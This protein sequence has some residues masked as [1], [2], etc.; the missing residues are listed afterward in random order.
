[1]PLG[2]SFKFGDSATRQS[3]KAALIPVRLGQYDGMI[4]VAVVDGAAPM[5]LSMNFVNEL[6]GVI[7]SV[8]LS[9]D[10]MWHAIRRRCR[11]HRLRGLSDPPP[12]ATIA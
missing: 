5:L 2:L 9:A 3:S 8:E 4:K 11:A 7:D 10:A 6:G 1:M 12:E